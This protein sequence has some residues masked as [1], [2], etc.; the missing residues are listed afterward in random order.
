MLSRPR[1]RLIRDLYKKVGGNPEE[2][3]IDPPND[4]ASIY[5]VKKEKS[6]PVTIIRRYFEDG[7]FQEIENELKKLL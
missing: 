1:T 2:I 6:K 7:D 3:V 5:E 4:W